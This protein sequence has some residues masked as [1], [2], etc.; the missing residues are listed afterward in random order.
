MDL[1]KFKSDFERS[2]IFMFKNGKVV[3]VFS[4]GE[5]VEG[6]NGIYYCIVG[7]LWKVRKIYYC[8]IGIF[9]VYKYSDYVVVLC[10]F[11]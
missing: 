7:I 1:V 3:I 9:N 5:I 4:N 11:Y 2:R 10:G 6:K 8:I